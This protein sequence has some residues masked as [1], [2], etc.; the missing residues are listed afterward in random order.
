MSASQQPTG[1]ICGCGQR[2]DLT[3]IVIMDDRSIQFGH[4][5]FSVSGTSGSMPQ[6]GW[7]CRPCCLRDHRL[8]IRLAGAA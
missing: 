2:D 7:K 1:P 5:P 4:E 8:W 3:W 6:M